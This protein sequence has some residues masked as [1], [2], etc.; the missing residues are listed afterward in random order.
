MKHIVKYKLFENNDEITI[1]DVAWLFFLTY[2][3]DGRL[4]IKSWCTDKRMN[5]H[6][7]DESLKKFSCVKIENGFYVSTDECKKIVDKYFGAKTF[8]E[9][10]LK[11]KEI[12]VLKSK[13]LIDSYYPINS[14]P[15]DL[16]LKK[17]PA[18]EKAFDLIQNRIVNHFNSQIS[19]TRILSQLSNSRRIKEFNFMKWSKANLPETF[20][21]YRG[22]KSNFNKD[23]N[24]EYTCWTTSLTEAERFAKYVF[25]GGKQFEPKYSDIQQVLVAEINISDVKVFIG[26]DEKEIILKEPVEIKEIIKIK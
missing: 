24:N 7:C 11:G 5:G 19:D 18:I 25:T 1:D 14:I 23:Y 6:I 4:S 3:Y 26:G 22:I 2:H 20:L 16:F 13:N 17:N 21:V 8:E 15:Y 9:A 12:N 10:I